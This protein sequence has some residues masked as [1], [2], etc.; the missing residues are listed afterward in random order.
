MAIAITMILIVNSK[1]GLRKFKLDKR[2][3]TFLSEIVHMRVQ[4]WCVLGDGG[5]THLTEDTTTT[6]ASQLSY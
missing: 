2:R 4:M 6:V 5:C 1:Q 3:K